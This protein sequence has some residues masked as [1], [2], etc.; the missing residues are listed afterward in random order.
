MQSYYYYYYYYYYERP[1]YLYV[2]KVI[3]ETLCPIWDETL[4]F[5]D[6]VVHGLRDELIRSP[7]VVIIEVYDHDIVVSHQLHVS[8]GTIGVDPVRIPGSGLSEHFGHEVL[9]GLDHHKNL[10][11]DC[12]FPTIVITRSLLKA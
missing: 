10:T 7:P 8:S 11:E 2:A 6:I 3:R 5:D 4:V 9:N 1:V 12:Q